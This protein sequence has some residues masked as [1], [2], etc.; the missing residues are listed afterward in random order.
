VPAA[1]ENLLATLS[2]SHFGLVEAVK[3]AGLGEGTNFLLIVDQFEEIFRF[4]E[5]GQTQQE[6]ANEFV[7]LLLEAAAQKEVPIYIVLTMRSD[8]ISIRLEALTHASLPGN[9]PGRGTKG[10]TPGL[11]ELK[12]W[13]WMAKRPG[14]A[15]SPRPLK[16]RAA[17]ADFSMND[18]PLGLPGEWN[19]SW[20]AGTHHTSVWRLEEPTTL[21]A[22]TELVSQMRFNEYVD[23]SDQNLGRFEFLW[24]PNLRR[25][26]RSRHASRQ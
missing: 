17:S 18:A 21:E 9:G 24:E 4:H 13:D 2:R 1:R 20:P 14:G 11:F 5:A 19:T 22:G 6:A 12:R 8:F 25:S 23:W 16:F 7:S 3:Q 15:G 10:T 26:T